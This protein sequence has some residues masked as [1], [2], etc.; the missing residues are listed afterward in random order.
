V[1]VTAQY[2]NLGINAIMLYEL[3]KEMKKGRVEYFETNLTLETND[4]VRAQFIYFKNHQNKV[5][6][7]YVKK[8]LPE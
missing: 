6:R 8:I 3:A 2:R 4:K 1:G 7:A 5:R